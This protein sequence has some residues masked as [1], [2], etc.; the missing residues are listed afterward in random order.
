LS[1]YTSKGPPKSELILNYRYNMIRAFTS[2]HTMR[3]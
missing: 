3:V 2:E 1:F